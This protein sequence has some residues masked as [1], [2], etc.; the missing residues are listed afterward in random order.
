M[1]HLILFGS[2]VLLACYA[3]AGD[4][5]LVSNYSEGQPLASINFIDDNGRT[6]STDEWRGLPAIIAPIYARCPVACPLIAEGLKRGLAGASARRGS[7][8]I[9]LFSFDPRDKPADLRRFRN[10]HHVPIDWT[11]AT[12]SAPDIHTLMDSIGVHYAQTK[13]SFV[14]PNVV[15]AITPGLKTAKYLFGTEYRSADLDSALAV[16]QGRNS[17]LDRYAGLILTALLLACA[18]SVAYLFQARITPQA[19]G[20]T[21]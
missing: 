3:Y 20:H 18:W 16:A 10:M 2:F 11:I 4:V 14:H 21:T 7:Y 5:T 1:K 13:N 6:R 17:W 12:A 15:V 19:K 8:R 9:I